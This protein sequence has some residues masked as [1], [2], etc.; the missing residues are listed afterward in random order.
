MNVDDA[1]EDAILSKI[2][3]WGQS[4]PAMEAFRSSHWKKLELF[5]VHTESLNINFREDYGCV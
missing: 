1:M 3:I 2:V 4:D 5:Y